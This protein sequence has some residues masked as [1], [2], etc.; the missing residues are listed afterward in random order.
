MVEQFLHLSGLT[1]R[2]LIFNRFLL[3]TADVRRGYETESMAAIG[4][5]CS[6]R[7]SRRICRL[8]K[9]GD[10]RSGMSVRVRA[11]GHARY[12]VKRIVR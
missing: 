11:G 1:S 10:Q 7:R 9:D 4:R 8:S 6:S 12:G 3:G 5:R 2:P